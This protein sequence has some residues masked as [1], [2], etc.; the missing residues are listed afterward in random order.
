M[1][2]YIVLI[3]KLL[4]LKITKFTRSGFE[5]LLETKR[6]EKHI[7]NLGGVPFHIADSHSFYYNHREIFI[8]E[9]YRFKSDNNRPVILDF[10]S[11]YGTSIVYFKSRDR[12]IL[13]Q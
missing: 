8:D 11:N 6:Y 4:G 10:G 3:F 7:V 13:H 2:K 5:Y 9:I 1:K 12:K